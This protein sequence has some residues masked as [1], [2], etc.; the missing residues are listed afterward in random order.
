MGFRQHQR[1]GDRSVA[2]QAGANTQSFTE[3]AGAAKEAV[4]A[5]E[6]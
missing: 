4:R 6:R 5:E 1:V 3:R 2:E